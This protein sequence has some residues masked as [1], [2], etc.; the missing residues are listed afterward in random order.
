[1]EAWLPVPEFEDRYEISSE[2]RVRSVDRTFNNRHYPSIILKQ[3]LG[4][5]GY[6]YFAACKDG[7]SRTIKTHRMVAK[8]FCENPQSKPHVNH[9]DGVKTHNA[10]SNLEWVTAREN[11][12]HATLNGLTVPHRGD[13]SCRAILMNEQAN[14]VRKAIIAGKNPVDIALEL[15]VNRA[16]IYDI[17][18][19]RKYASASTADLVE[20]CKL[21]K[22]DRKA[23]Q[24]YKL[25]DEKVLELIAHLMRGNSVTSTAEVFGVQRNLVSC[26]N[27]GSKR[28]DV[29]P[30]CGTRPPYLRNNAVMSALKHRRAELKPAAAESDM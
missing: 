11:S 14:E 6:Y 29:M 22:K 25:T 17:R 3:N 27:R 15:G 16:T 20:Q 5:T 24:A 12:I 7:V 13:E 1:M 2:G 18:H 26:I 10:A 21:F 28:T 9:I 30:P 19:G 8:V 4:K 23:H